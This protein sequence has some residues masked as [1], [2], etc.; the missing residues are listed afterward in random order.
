MDRIL[1]QVDEL[2]CKELK[3]LINGLEDI[4]RMKLMSEIQRSLYEEE[5]LLTEI[6]QVL[7]QI[8]DE[9]NN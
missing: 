2:N 5:H 1:D 8:T 4:Y 3:K 9:N 6:L 7:S